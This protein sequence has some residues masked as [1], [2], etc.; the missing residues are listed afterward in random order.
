MTTLR[1]GIIS[2]FL[3]LLLAAATLVGGGLGPTL[4]DVIHNHAEQADAEG[5]C[6]H[7][8]HGT[9]FEAYHSSLDVS[10][11]VFHSR[12]PQ[13]VRT[14]SDD[15]TQLATDVELLSMSVRVMH[16]LPMLDGPGSRGPPEYT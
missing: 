5:H 4:H 8:E 12:P 15:M 1:S 6:S 11:C 13:S 10:D 3:S 16:G 7:S 9:S 14:E 2:P